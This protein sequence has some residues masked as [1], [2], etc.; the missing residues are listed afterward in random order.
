MIILLKSLL[1]G[2]SISIVGFLLSTLLMFYDK[3]FSLKK[4]HFW[5]QVLIAFFATGFLY[6]IIAEVSGLNKWYCRNT[7]L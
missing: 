7:V 1:S 2:L 4:Y 3:N 5:K 6:N